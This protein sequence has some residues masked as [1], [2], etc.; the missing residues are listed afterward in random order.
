MFQTTKQKCDD[1]GMNLRPVLSYLRFISIKFSPFSSDIVE[2]GTTEAT[3]QLATQ[4][5][6]RLRV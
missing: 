2:D 5:G 6:R 4:A 1:E 3:R